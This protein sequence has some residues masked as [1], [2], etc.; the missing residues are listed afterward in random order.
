MVI[1]HYSFVMVSHNAFI[2]HLNSV[3]TAISTPN[4]CLCLIS[5]FGPDCNYNTAS[6]HLVYCH[7]KWPE[8]HKYWCI[9]DSFVSSKKNMSFVFIAKGIITINSIS[10]AC[11]YLSALSF[12]ISFSKETYY[13]VCAI[14]MI[15]HHTRK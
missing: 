7:K 13:R 1:N 6:L 9:F 12:S 5:I 3:R 10:N 15:S 4:T 14:V 8:Q 2:F 11:F